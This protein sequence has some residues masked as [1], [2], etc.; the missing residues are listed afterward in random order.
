MVKA[1][2][3]GAAGRGQAGAEMEGGAVSRWLWRLGG[4]A[5]LGAWSTSERI[6]VQD[7]VCLEFQMKS[8][9]PLA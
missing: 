7:T 3:S 1:G 5:D 8:T 4:G 2:P 6:N 9:G